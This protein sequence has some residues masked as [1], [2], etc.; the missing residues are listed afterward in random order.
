MFVKKLVI[1]IFTSERQELALTLY[2][3]NSGGRIEENM[4]AIENGE[5]RIQIQEGSFYEYKIDD[6][7]CLQPSK[8]VSQSKINISS[9]YIAPGIYVGTL[10]IDVL[11][12]TSLQKCGEIKL[13]VQSVKTTYREDYRH[14]L[15]EITERCTELLLLHSSPVA[16]YFEVNCIACA[17]TLYQRFAFIKS[18]L[19]SVEFNDAVHK[20]LSSP[21]TRWRESETI[22]DIRSIRRFSSS[23]IRQLCNETNRFDLPADHVLHKTIASVPSKLRV[24]HKTETDDTPENRFVKHALIVFQTLCSDFRAKVKDSDRIKREAGLLED[25]LEHFLSHSIFKEITPPKTIPLNSPVLQR[26]AGYREVLR[27]WLMFDLAAKMVWHGGND[28]YSGNKRDVAT[29]YEYWVFFKLLE[30]VCAVFKI[31]ASSNKNLI[32]ETSDSI[33]LKL[34]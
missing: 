22:K 24:N 29:L 7:F 1:P 30:I 16:Q 27:V 33:G 5:A 14:M 10:T 9:G 11:K 6:G 3:E 23:T 34:K 20:I 13:E 26:K 25:K 19:D 32:E 15:G 4:D 31:E 17:N 18:I 12:S 8:I 21:V 28:V 2:A